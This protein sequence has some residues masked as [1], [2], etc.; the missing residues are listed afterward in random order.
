MRKD[1]G[2]RALNW[3]LC[4]VAALVSALVLS[5]CGSAPEPVPTTQ[6][7][8]TQVTRPTTQPSAT[9]AGSAPDATVLP[10]GISATLIQQRSDVA[11]RE[12]QV[13][14]RNDR[15]DGIT[16]G[17]VSVADDRFEGIAARAVDRESSLAA[18]AS[19]DVRVVLPP[20]RC[21]SGHEGMSTVTLHLVIDGSDITASAPVDDALDVLPGI[22][23]RE[24]L[25][26][27]LAEV[28][29]LEL[30]EFV[31][32]PPGEPAHIHL[33]VTPTSAGRARIVSVQSTPLLTFDGDDPTTEHPI[34]LEIGPRSEQ[35][36]LEIP[37]VP[38]RCDPHVVQEDKVGTVF[39][40]DVE[41]E[42]VAGRI[43]LPAPPEMKST[44]L[45][46]VADWCDF[47]S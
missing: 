37:L 41:V 10:E 44:I 11:E 23:A 1:A 14:I 12:M 17:D 35:V 43:T 6:P 3:V 13:R 32:S 26:E 18:G 16:V 33:Q 21:G 39:V 4:T 7:S 2:R 34:G 46:W 9:Q 42:G 40:F 15:D 20:M 29:E 36:T 5:G 47:G 45:T 24:C 28:A 25:G 31:P 19:V 8:T 38:Q 27:A 22:H 30:V